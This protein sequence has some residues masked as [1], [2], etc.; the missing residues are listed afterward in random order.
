M[1]GNISPYW[2][3]LGLG[4]LLLAVEV[5]IV[6]IGFFLCLGSAAVIMAALTFLFPGLSWL[7]ALSI[8]SALS[9]LSIWFWFAVI[10][11]R[12]S[13]RDKEENELLNVKTRQLIGYRGELLEALKGGRGRIKVNDSPWMVQAE[14]DYPAGTLVEVTD[15]AGITLIVRAV[16]E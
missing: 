14:K 6:P 2:I 4:C 1:L 12:R 11:K 13:T 16:E 9:V 5:L 7:W 3:W 10:R 15:V 8:Y